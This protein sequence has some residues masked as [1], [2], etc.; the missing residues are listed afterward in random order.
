MTAYQHNVDI[1]LQIRVD[2]GTR[3]LLSG[4]STRHLVAKSALAVL[5]FRI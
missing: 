3:C 2:F 1:T 4:T 5:F